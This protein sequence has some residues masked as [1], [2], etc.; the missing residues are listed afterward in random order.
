[1]HLAYG[2]LFSTLFIIMNNSHLQVRV[3]YDVIINS[4]TQ[5][6][7]YHHV[8]MVLLF[9]SPLL[10]PLIYVGCN[11]RYREYILSIFDKCWSRIKPKIIHDY[12]VETDYTVTTVQRGNGTT[13]C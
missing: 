1:M 13:S 10:N 4:P 8:T 7:T 9:L 5:D 11:R 3:F 12:S 2:L 6:E